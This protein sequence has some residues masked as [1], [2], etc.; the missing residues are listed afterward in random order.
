MV[1]AVALFSGGLDSQLAVQM[2]REQGGS[3][4]GITFATPFFTPETAIKAA[5]DLNVPLKIIDFTEEH[6]EII[7]SPV[8]G[9][10]KNLNPCIDCHALMIKKAGQYMEEIEAQFIITGEVLGERPKS[11][12]YKA[13]QIV[14]KDSGYEGLVLRPLSAQMLPP[15]IAEEKDWV[16]RKRLGSIQGRSRKPQMALATKYGLKEYPSPAG[17]CLLTVENISNRLKDLLQQGEKISRSDLE[18]LKVGRHFRL[19]EKVKIVVGRDKEENQKIEDLAQ[20]GD[21]IIKASNVPGPT[22]LYRGKPEEN[23]IQLSASI[24]IRYSG[25]G[26]EGDYVSIWEEGEKKELEKVI[27]PLTE[28]KI[29]L[30]RIN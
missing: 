22:T 14:E 8:H 18:L 29:N 4:L 6:L 15:T 3:V 19:G 2:V 30:Y 21:L 17:G 24:T 1:K 16:D 20:G 28:D 23:S 12:N 5:E 27:E 10:G 9:Y 26:P 25:A 13:L 7:K 11:Q